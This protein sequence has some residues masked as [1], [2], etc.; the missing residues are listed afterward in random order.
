M[1]V[2]LSP[3]SKKKL[4][5]DL[6]N[7]YGCNSII[8]LA[9]KLNISAKTLD[10]WL[11]NQA[12]FIPIKFLL[13]SELNNFRI[14]K[15][16]K[17]NWGQ[18]LGGK[19]SQLKII[20][21]RGSQEIKR[22]QSLGGKNSAITKSIKEKELFSINLEDPIFLE[23]YGALIG[24]G[25]LSG[26]ESKSKWQIGLCGHL[27]LDRN[28]ILFMQENIQNMF[29]RKGFIY[30][31]EKGNV[32]NFLFRHKILYKY[33]G[34]NLKFPTGKKTSLKI[35]NKIYNFGFSHVRHVIRGIFDTDGSFFLA[36]RK[37]NNVAPMLSIH[38]NAPI[39]IKQIGEMLKENGFKAHYSDKGTMIRLVGNKQ[40]RKWME[41]IGS[42]NKKHLDKIENFRI[43]YKNF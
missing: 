6:K 37:N 34:N 43:K 38:M 32:I 23:F 27:N 35:A 29:N 17:S 39:L 3:S 30:N 21:E 12:R 40:L 31:Y 42:S 7:K 8:E 26:L 33:L 1:R 14:I 41:E 11:Y 25:W 36:K 5:Q 18:S 19:N 20:K 2:L 15:K 24:D 13:D 16:Q 10:T 22:M 4:Y 9:L 28:Y